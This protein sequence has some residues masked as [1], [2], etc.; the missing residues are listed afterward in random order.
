[1]YNDLIE[2]LINAEIAPCNVL[3][4]E[5]QDDWCNGGE[6]CTGKDCSPHRC[7]EHYIYRILGVLKK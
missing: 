6:H 4:D 2:E 1:M 7:W 3:K 5:V